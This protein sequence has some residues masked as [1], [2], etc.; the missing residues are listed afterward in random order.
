MGE[1][2]GMYLQTHPHHRQSHR[3]ASETEKGD[4]GRG[5]GRRVLRGEDGTAEGRGGSVR[6]FRRPRSSSGEL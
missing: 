2:A 4:D 3:R 5:S 1:G 6:A